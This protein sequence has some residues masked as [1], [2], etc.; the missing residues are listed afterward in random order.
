M[1]VTCTPL[2]LLR[3][4]LHRDLFHCAHPTTRTCLWFIWAGTLD[5]DQAITLNCRGDALKTMPVTGLE[6]ALKE[7][8]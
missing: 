4:H 7:D 8:A 6:H 2:E 5:V 1:F 3:V